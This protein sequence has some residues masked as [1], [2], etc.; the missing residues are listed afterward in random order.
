[1]K[2]AE[3][4]L[5]IVLLK[6]GDPAFDDKSFCGFRDF[7]L[8]KLDTMSP[9]EKMLKLYACFW[10]RENIEE[11]FGKKKVSFFLLLLLIYGRG[12]RIV[13]F[14][15][16]RIGKI[17]PVCFFH[18]RTGNLYIKPIIIN[19]SFYWVDLCLKSQKILFC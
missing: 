7:F 8:K 4:K 5:Q 18:A 19:M 13:I 12:P 15:F 3:K 17:S 11:T 9:F 6:E 14:K 10:L 16:S 2:F 1:M